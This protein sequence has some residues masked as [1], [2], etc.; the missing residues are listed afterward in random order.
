MISITYCSHS[1]NRMNHLPLLK[2]RLPCRRIQ[3]IGLNLLS[4]ITIT[5]TSLLR[6]LLSLPTMGTCRRTISTSFRNQTRLL[7]LLPLRITLLPNSSTTTHTSILPFPA[8]RQIN[9]SSLFPM[10]TQCSAATC[11]RISLSLCLCITS[12]LL[13]PFLHLTSPLI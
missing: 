6:Y 4:I 7:L 11:S 2:F 10:G 13:D 9:Q 12:H 5:P 3:S 8:Y 1:V